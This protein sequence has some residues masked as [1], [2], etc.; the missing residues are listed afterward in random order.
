MKNFGT[1]LALGLGAV[2]V[3]MFVK[4][5]P[6]EEFPSE[7][8]GDPDKPPPGGPLSEEAAAEI[9]VISVAQPMMGVSQ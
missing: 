1:I 9:E 6:V 8:P 7:I 4:R 2:A 5:Q 3:Y